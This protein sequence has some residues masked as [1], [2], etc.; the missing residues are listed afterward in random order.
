MCS[1]CSADIRGYFNTERN[2][3]HVT[4]DAAMG[5]QRRRIDLYP[6]SSEQATAEFAAADI[7]GSSDQ[8]EVLTLHARIRT[9]TRQQS[10]F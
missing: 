1:H 5:G 2:A 9:V 7:S 3:L 10:M 6:E 8:A 4:G